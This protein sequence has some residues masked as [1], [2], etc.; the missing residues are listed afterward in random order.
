MNVKF[1]IQKDHLIRAL[2]KTPFDF[3]AV[4]AC[5]DTIFVMKGLLPGRIK[6]V[7]HDPH[8]GCGH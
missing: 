1:T 6:N 4:L 5:I 2:L 3:Y 8:M 7:D